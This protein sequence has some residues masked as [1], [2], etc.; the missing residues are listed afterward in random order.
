MA[1][2]NNKRIN[3]LLAIFFIFA[4]G[5]MGRMFYWQILKHS[6]YIALAEG[7]R[8]FLSTLFPERGDILIS[9][10]TNSSLPS[11]AV[12]YFPVAV[13]KPGYS[14]YAVPIKIKDASVSAETL[15]KILDLDKSEVKARLVKAGSRYEVIARKVSEEKVSAIKEAKITGIGFEPE[16]WRYWPENN[17]LA[18]VLGFVGFSGDKREGQYGIE[19]YFNKELE[20]KT[21]IIEA[22]RDT[23]GKLI[24]LGMKQYQPAENGSDIV[25]TIDRAIQYQVEKELGAMAKE[26]DAEGAQAIVIEPATGKILAMANW[27]SF[28]LN[29]YSSAGS[30]DLFL[31][32]NIQSRYEPGSV[33]KPF[34]MAVAINEDRITPD[35]TYEDKG[36]LV[37][38]GWPVTN[39]EN[40]V[41]GVQTMTQVLENSINTGAIFAASRVSKDIFQSYFKN[42]GFDVPTG[43]ELQG[44]ISGD[45]SNL[46]TRKDIA[47]A[48]ASF[49]QGIAM[50]PL[51]IITA[52]GSLINGGRLMKPY[53]VDKV[54]KSDDT[55]EET[56]PEV[57][58]SI[59]SPETS[60]KVTSM[61]VQVVEKGI[62]KHA[63]IKGYWI[64]GKTGTAQVSFVNKR[65]YSDKTIHTFLGFGSAPDPKFAILVKI[66]SP[67]KVKYAESS[68]TPVFH[69]IAKFMVSYMGIAPNR[70]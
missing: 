40:K 39:A 23:G 46:D 38:D 49:G 15:A 63:K 3:F 28:D 58:R 1:D 16:N 50:T 53:I 45:L 9:D 56:K 32:K 47:Y 30:F 13:N 42:F 48:N 34:T 4:L 26:V 55:V 57:V 24:S 10:K 61:L 59:I 64:G 19:G 2:S 29:N 18:Q 41:Y 67:K 68:V 7:Q 33:I 70:K 62:S 60:A 6:V 14:V 65:G 8:V 5:I 69:N 25:L 27:P 21:G 44:E 43:I 22:E 17:L 35:T 31:N 37:I 52:F 20:G 51:E 54:I 66:D 11:G 12:P 36:S